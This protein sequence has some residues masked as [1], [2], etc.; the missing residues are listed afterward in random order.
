MRQ[1]LS[2]ALAEDRFA[3]R[4]ND[5]V[6]N[7]LWTCELEARIRVRLRRAL[8]ADSTPD[9]PAAYSIYVKNVSPQYPHG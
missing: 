7:A 9:A 8:R 5:Y 3:A 1:Y 2:A 4:S 6:R